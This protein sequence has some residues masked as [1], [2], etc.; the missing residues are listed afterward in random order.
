MD[1]VTVAL[2]LEAPTVAR[3]PASTNA[4]RTPNVGLYPKL[5]PLLVTVD[6]SAVADPTLY[7]HVLASDFHRAP[8]KRVTKDPLPGADYELLVN[9]TPTVV[10]LTSLL[11]S[12]TTT[13]L[14][15]T[16]V[17]SKA[18]SKLIPGVRKTV[19]S[20]PPIRENVPKHDASS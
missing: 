15:N 7:P 11:S 17:T 8:Q 3:S 9:G 18:W 10:G 2:A 5:P 4:A 16:T 1:Q 12:S 19:C 13:P 6:Q 14:K 20:L